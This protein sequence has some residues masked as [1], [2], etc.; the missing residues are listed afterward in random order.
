MAD[1]S[2]SKFHAFFKEEAGQ[3]FLADA[4]S[5]NGTFVDGERALS[6]KQGKPVALKSG[7]LVKFG[8]LEFRFVDVKELVALARQLR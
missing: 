1:I 6:T 5:R 2:I 4:E 7:S 3:Y 8:G